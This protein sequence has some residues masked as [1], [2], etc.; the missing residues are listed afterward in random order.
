M[1]TTWVQYPAH[2]FV[3]ASAGACTVLKEVKPGTHQ[4]VSL[5]MP[6]IDDDDD[7]ER[8]EVCSGRPSKDPSD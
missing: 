1:Y 4:I 3:K 6:L 7:D 8:F 2:C 5:R